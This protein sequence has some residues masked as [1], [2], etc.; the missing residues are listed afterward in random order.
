[1]GEM[2]NAG[3]ENEEPNNRAGKRQYQE[4]NH[5]VC[6][7]DPSLYQYHSLRGSAALL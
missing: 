2:E 5:A 4:K 3:L 7:F 1:V 6:V